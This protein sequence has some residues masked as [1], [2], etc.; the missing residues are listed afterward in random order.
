MKSTKLNDKNLLVEFIFLIISTIW[1]VFNSTTTILLKVIKNVEELIDQKYNVIKCKRK[2][3]QY[4]YIL[5]SINFLKKDYVSAEKLLIKNIDE[6]YVFLMKFEFLVSS[7]DYLTPLYSNLILIIDL[8][9]NSNNLEKIPHY[10][11]IVDK[12]IAKFTSACYLDYVK[13]VE[14]L[15]RKQQIALLENNIN[16]SFLYFNK[17][18][19]LLKGLDQKKIKNL[20]F[21]T[22]KCIPYLIEY[23]Y[24][25]EELNYV[26]DE[27]TK[28]IKTSIKL[29]EKEHTQ[30]TNYINILLDVISKNNILLDNEMKK[31]YLK[32]KDTVLKKYKLGKIHFSDVLN[33]LYNVLLIYFESDSK[34]K[35]IL[36]KELISFLKK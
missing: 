2:L 3:S 4:L 9:I 8:Y 14:I 16:D 24:P 32:L 27:L 10:L 34:E 15:E 17:R 18:Y 11:E 30:A 20:C 36:N 1:N 13:E 26:F 28:C 23:N 19:E 6:V 31:L 5:A 33:N 22:I 25:T 21:E 7:Y 29:V 12:L 35:D